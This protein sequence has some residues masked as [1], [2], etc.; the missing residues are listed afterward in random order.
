MFR[1]G[2]LKTAKI[3][4]IK[5]LGK[6]GE[7]IAHLV[8][9]PEHG[10]CVR[11]TF[12]ITSKQFSTPLF[13]K[14]LEIMKKVKDPHM[15]RFLGQE[16][17]KPITYHE[18]VPIGKKHEH[19]SKEREAVISELDSKAET[20]TGAGIKDLASDNLVRT[21]EGGLKAIDFLVDG[22][23]RQTSR[24]GQ[25]KRA[26]ESGG[27]KAMGKKI[28]EFDQEAISHK[29][30]AQIM[31]NANLPKPERDKLIEKATKPE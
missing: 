19:K 31:R 9:H 6:G 23:L 12:N 16:G 20:A 17:D 24:R 26:L 21:P 30:R 13:N 22:P 2:F 8:D 27:P 14:K 4:V 28:Q 18:Y 1:L 25:L 15:A 5:E 10:Q 11:K 29:S 7:G 3:K